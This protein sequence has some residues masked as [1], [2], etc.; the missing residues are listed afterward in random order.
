MPQDKLR[1]KG[2][3]PQFIDHT[4]LRPEA[5]SVDVQ[6][7]CNEAINN[8]F[9][10]VC[11]NPW[12]VEL[13][14]HYLSDGNVSTCAVIGFPLGASP[15]RVKLAEAYAVLEA[16]ADELDMVLAISALKDGDLATVEDDI[17][18][19]K[20]A[21][22][23]KILK[24]ILETCLLTHE[25]KIAA[26]QAAHRA[27][28]DFVKTS[29]GFSHGGAAIA[30]VRLLRETVGVDL[31]VKASGGIRSGPDVHAMIDA[32]ASRIGSSSGAALL[33]DATK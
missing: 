29:T 11:V 27:R 7:Y 14:A 4:L 18:Q 32:G 13:A 19:I 30:D 20:Q 21:C 12:F 10:S 26:C 15:T 24:V 25:E 2:D 5:T 33:S 3:L 28:A 1:T 9:K 17:R 22:G 6:R 23:P 31:G 8:G 16:G